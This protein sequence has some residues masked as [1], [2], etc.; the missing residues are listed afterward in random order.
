M[1]YKKI[2]TFLFSFL[3][4][5][6]IINSLVAGPNED[7]TEEQRKN[8]SKVFARYLYC[9][10]CRP[11]E[12]EERNNYVRLRNDLIW[13]S[14]DYKKLVYSFMIYT[15]FKLTPEISLRKKHEGAFL[16]LL[17]DYIIDLHEPKES[18]H[19]KDA[20]LKMTLNLGML[21]GSYLQGKEG[22]CPDKEQML[23]FLEE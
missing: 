18:P 22:I 10:S 15:N 3:S 17:E 4:Y 5:V 12:S 11:K 1:F 7:Y 2:Y 6:C 8:A 16:R 21:E 20:G 13:R 23:K 19:Y 14:E 9:S